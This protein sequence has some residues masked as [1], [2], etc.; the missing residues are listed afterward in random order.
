MGLP[1]REL[2]P[3]PLPSKTFA[4]M[5]TDLSPVSPIAWAQSPTLYDS[6]TTDTSDGDT[7]DDNI[8]YYDNSYD[9]NP[10]DDIS[11]DDTS[12]D[13]TS[14]GDTFYDERPVDPT[15]VTLHETFYLESGDVEVLCESSLFRV[16]AAVLSLR[17]PVLRRTFSRTNLATAT[18]P[19]GYPRLV[20]PDT[21]EDFATLLG[22]IYHPAFVTSSVYC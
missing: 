13:D 5:E 3:L 22:I 20:S 10:Y 16:H 21:P 12:C 1:D 8:S 15:A 14:G 4:T 7:S 9:D 11:Y 17:S 19:H 2:E 6:T 18:S